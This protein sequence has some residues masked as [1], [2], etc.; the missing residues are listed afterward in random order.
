MDIAFLQKLERLTDEELDYVFKATMAEDDLGYGIEQETGLGVWLL[1]QRDLIQAAICHADLIRQYAQPNHH[2]RLAFLQ[3]AVAILKRV[4][5]I[6][7]AAIAVISEKL[8]R[9]G[10][11]HFCLQDSRQSIN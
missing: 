5:A 7:E 2:Q 3:D 8:L 4:L 1:T 9:I 10:L 11:P 6:P